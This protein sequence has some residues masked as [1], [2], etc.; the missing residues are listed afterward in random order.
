MGKKKLFGAVGKEDRTGEAPF[1]GLE[2]R[3][4]RGGGA[5]RESKASWPRQGTG[6]KVG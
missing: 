2:G 6:W 5:A 1:V 4:D 3:P